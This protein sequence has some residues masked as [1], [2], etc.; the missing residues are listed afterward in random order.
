MAII[1]PFRALRP[2]PELASQICELPYDVMTSDEARQ[3]V[4]GKPL[5]FLHVSK[6][7]IDLP[8]EISPYNSMVYEKG[9]KNFMQFIFDGRLRQ[10]QNASFY[11]YRQIMGQHQ[12]TGLVAVASAQDYENNV[13]KKHEL[14]R[15]EKEE[16]R[17]QHIETLNAQTGP[18][19]LVYQSQPELD[20]YFSRKILDKPDVDFIASDN[21]QHSSWTINGID[22]IEYIKTA[23]AN[24]PSLYIADGHHRSAAAHRVWKMRHGTGNSSHFLSVIFPHNQVQIMPYNRVVKDLNSL[25]FESFIEALRR[26]GDIKPTI[27]PKPP[28]KR[29]CCFY[30]NHQWYL[31]TF[32]PSLI[33]QKDLVLTL[34]VSLLQNLVLA[35]ILGINDPRT[36][37]R[38]SFVGGIR[39]VEEL[40]KGVNEGTYAVAFSMYPTGIEEVIDIADAGGILPP[41]S[42]WFE[43]KLRDGMF[44]H[45]I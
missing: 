21:V 14:T 38:I 12:Q 10:D 4:L 18:V 45:L 37:D 17:V 35:P 44:C 42:T 13:I 24:I 23:F 6:P 39:G 26:V 40:E 31:L 43:P 8:R 28:G 1:C 34:D 32:H 2:I 30:A 22:D 36:S 33:S 29:Q 16:D 15:L 11:L 19:F 3:M 27:D 5:S 20:A 9:M 41:K 25:S 7:E